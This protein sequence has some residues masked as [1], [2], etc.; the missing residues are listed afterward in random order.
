MTLFGLAMR[1]ESFM[2]LNGS[3]GGRADCQIGPAHAIDDAAGV[4][5]VDEWRIKIILTRGVQ[6][7]FVGDDSIA[8]AGAVEF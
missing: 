2:A 8:R 1:A 5:V 6:R 3:N 7:R 4:L